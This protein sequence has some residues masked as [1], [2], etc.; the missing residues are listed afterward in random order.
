ML[1]FARAGI[2]IEWQAWSY[3]IGYAWGATRGVLYGPNPRR[4]S[5]KIHWWADAEKALSGIVV[6]T[7]S[8]AS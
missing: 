1:H 4:C 6:R 7:H 8:L 3:A 5:P 2:A